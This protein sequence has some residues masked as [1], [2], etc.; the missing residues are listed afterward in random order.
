VNTYEYWVGGKLVER[1]QVLSDE[2]EGGSSYDDTR[3]GLLILE[4]ER[5]GVLDGWYR[6]G[7]Y[8]PYQ[9]VTDELGAMTV[10]DLRDALR[11]R[12]LPTAGNKADPI[13]RLRA[14]EMGVPAPDAEEA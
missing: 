11:D 13:M 6:E 5:T 10:E 7:E 3:I 2:S 12:G 9:E 8:Q 4:R 1:Q 14:S